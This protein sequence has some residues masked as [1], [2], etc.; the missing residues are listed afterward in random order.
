[1]SEWMERLFHGARQYQRWLKAPE[2]VMSPQAM[3]AKGMTERINET[4]EEKADRIGVPLIPKRP[5][6][7][8]PQADPW[9]KPVDETNPTVGV[10]GECGIEVKRIMYFSCGNDRC[11]VQQ[12][13]TYDTHNNRS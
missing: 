6:P 3:I 13:P 8:K 9:K 7:R 2:G 12:R 4:P 1:M 10:C 11:P 5:R